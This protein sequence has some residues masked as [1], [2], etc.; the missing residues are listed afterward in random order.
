M[1]NRLDTDRAWTDSYGLEAEKSHTAKGEPN[2]S[3]LVRTRRAGRL[4]LPRQLIA[5]VSRMGEKGVERRTALR[6]GRNGAR[7][8]LA[9][10]FEDTLRNYCWQASYAAPLQKLRPRP[11]RKSFRKSFYW[12][13]RFSNSH[14]WRCVLDFVNRCS[15]CRTFAKP[16]RR[17][18]RLFLVLQIPANRPAASMRDTVPLGN[19]SAGRRERKRKRIGSRRGYRGRARMDQA[20]APPLFSRARISWPSRF[21]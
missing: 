1:S 8:V 17:K 2:S 12:S 11:P 9:S 15:V 4:S 7:G 16:S 3:D 19:T 21:R 13:S 5:C 18:L 10:C 6:G 20:A 14:L